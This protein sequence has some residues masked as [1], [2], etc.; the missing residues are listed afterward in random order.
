LLVRRYRLREF[1]E[2]SCFSHVKW[3]GVLHVTRL[4]AAVL[5]VELAVGEGRGRALA[6]LCRGA[7]GHPPVRAGANA[8]AR[9]LKRSLSRAGLPPKRMHLE[10]AA[11]RRAN[12]READA[13]SMTHRGLS[14]CGSSRCSPN[15]RPNT[16]SKAVRACL[17]SPRPTYR[18]GCALGSQR[19]TSDALPLPFTALS[20]P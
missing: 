8:A 7:G 13:F 20:R 14:I 19:P 15:R 9:R 3:Q 2:A 1:R 11:E 17:S 5:G 18:L 10:T 6:S 12:E 4:D 16:Y